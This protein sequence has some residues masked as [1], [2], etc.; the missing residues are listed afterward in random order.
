MKYNSK[1]NF[2][3]LVLLLASC[4]KDFIDRPSENGP[5]LDVYYNTAAEVNAATGLLY[6]TIWYDWQDKAFHAIGEAQGG[7][8]LTPNGDS[9]YGSGVYNN[10]KVQSTDVL[11]AASWKSLYKVAV[12]QQF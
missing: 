12:M 6:N 8:M 4:S 9:N 11:V 5:T 1:Y 7:N 2:L 3:F 10:F